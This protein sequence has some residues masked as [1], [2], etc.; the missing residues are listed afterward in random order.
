M[1]RWKLPVFPEQSGKTFAVTGGNAG[2]GYFV[3]EHLAA[4]GARV[5]IAARSEQK[6]KAAKGAI[7]SRVPSAHVDLLVSISRTSHLCGEQPTG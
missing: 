3:S 6:S 2:I 5:I 1:T 7:V 4:A